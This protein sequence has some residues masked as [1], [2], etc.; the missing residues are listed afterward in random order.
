MA[1]RAVYLTLLLATGMA[2]GPARAEEDDWKPTCQPV[3]EDDRVTL[4]SPLFSFVLEMRDGLRARSWTNHRTG[5]TVDLGG[6]PE[7]EADLGPLGGPLETPRWTAAEL[8]GEGKGDSVGN[9]TFRVVSEDRRLTAVVEYVWSKDEPVLQKWVTLTNSSQTPLQLLNVRLG[10]YRTAARLEQREQ[11]F[12]VYLDGEFFASLAHPAGFATAQDGQVRLFHHPGV[13]LAPGDERCCMEAVYGVGACAGGAR[14]AF[15]EHVRGRMRRVRRNHNVPYVIFD[16]FG[17]W[18]EG[19]NH[20]FFTQ[21]TEAHMLHSLQRLGTS[22]EAT[23]CRF[24]I[25]NIHFWVDHAG[26][27][28]RLDPERFPQGIAP[29]K[30]RLDQL[31]IAPGLWIDSSMASWSI[32]RNPAAAAS[33]TEDRGWFCRASEPVRSMYRD[34]FLHH[35]RENGV[36]LVKFDNLRSV[37]NNME[38][39]HLPGVY[40]T[41]AIANSVAEFLEELD[42]ACPDVLLILYWGHRSPWWLLVGDT[43]FDSGIGIE[44]ATPALQPAPCARDSVTQKLDQAQEYARDIPA[45]GKDSLGV[46]LSD[47]GWNSSIGKERWQEG[48]VMDMCRGSMLIQLWADRDWMS[49]PEWEQLADFITLLRRRSGCFERPRWILGSPS[50]DEPYG[51]C[52]TDGERAFLAIHNATWE[53]R[54]VAL[55]LGPDF[56]LPAGRRWDIY[57]RHPDPARLVGESEESESFGDLASMA[58]R[59]FQV[60]LLEVVAAGAAPALHKELPTRQISM[61]FAEASQALDVAVSKIEPSERAEVKERWTVLQPR[62]AQSAGGATLTVQEDGTILAGGTNPSPDTYTIVADTD[63]ERVTGVRIEVLPHSSL[64][65]RGPGRCFNGNLALTEVG[66]QAAPR[67]NETAIQ[68][69]TFPRALADFSQTSHGGFPVAGAIDGDPRTAWSIFPQVNMPHTAVL[70]AR[71]PFGASE[72]TVLTFSLRQGYLDGPPDHTIGRLR[73]A[74]TT[75]PPPFDQPVGVGP[76]ALKVQLTAPSSQSGG[77]VV[78]AAQLMQGG[79]PV[80]Q[81]NIG[82]HFTA[83]ARLAD[84]SAECRDVLGKETYPSAWQA[85]RIPI[86]P[87]SASQRLALTVTT[88]LSEDLAFRAYFLP[89]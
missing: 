24:D 18:P 38:H 49:P 35:M 14:E 22:Q 71:E 33:F 79:Q 60:V 17:S 16:N 85:W 88:D 6:G 32:G 80:A 51:Y 15:V 12:P 59:P 61:A 58:L 56:G 89:R 48:L 54:V 41:E 55:T 47:W 84:Q 82:T 36:R 62:S 9:A 23:G 31:H 87:G 45:L 83:A 73:L 81:H 30:E 5:H 52:C 21:N 57:R 4:R 72:G 86:A 28:K 44:A 19:E 40:S 67:N 53:D 64:P 74:V 76:Q 39:G 68:P 3:V 70:E 63:L 66:L 69:V 43:L 2:R 37:C 29:I 75:D 25:C 27:L 10:D 13:T 65:A 78:I 42:E 8:G 77:T 50:K 11:G 26:D 34:A 20:A 46:W 1:M 7:L